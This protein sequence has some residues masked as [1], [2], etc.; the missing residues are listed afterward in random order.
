MIVT[1]L[2]Q[3]SGSAGQNRSSCKFGVDGVA[4][5]T[6]PAMCLVRLVDLDDTDPGAVQV[7]GQRGA[8]GMGALHS[9]L[10][11]PAQMR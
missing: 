3:G 2:G 9:S 5:A 1:G 11:H 6:T 4:L 7:T 8:I 10:P